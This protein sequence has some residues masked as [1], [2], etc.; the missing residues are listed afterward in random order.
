MSTFTLSSLVG[1]ERGE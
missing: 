1:P